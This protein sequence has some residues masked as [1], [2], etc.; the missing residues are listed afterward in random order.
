MKVTDLEGNVT[1]WKVK[2]SPVTKDNRVRS[3]LHR[4]ARGLIHE[5]YPTVVLLEEAPIVVKPRNVLYLD[6]YI[7]LH[8]IAVEVHGR[9]HYEYVRHFHRN[10]MAFL[11]HLSR[12]RDK[13]EW[14]ELNDITLI[15]LPYN[16]DADEWRRKFN[17]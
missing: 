7:P 6:F 3:S 5:V 1:T 16:E 14:C 10:R 13:A 11:K 15:V 17:D 2:A 9:Q 8:N 4:Q 12:D